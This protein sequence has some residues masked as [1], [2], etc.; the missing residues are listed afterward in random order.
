M[1]QTRNFTPEARF[2]Q[3]EG[4]LQDGNSR[5]NPT[6]LRPGERKL[7]RHFRQRYDERR[8]AFWRSRL[9]F[10]TA[11]SLVGE[12]FFMPACR[13]MGLF[14]SAAI[15]LLTAR[16]AA[17]EEPGAAM[18][19]LLDAGW[20]I[21]PQAR[22]AAD[23]QFPLL[24]ESADMN[25]DASEAIW[26]VL[27]QQRRFGEAQRRLD[28]HLRRW[29]NDLLAL[30]AKAWILI[31][32][33]SYS[34][35]FP[36]AERV[37]TA[38]IASA[39]KTEADRTEQEES[40]AF[41]GR[42]AGFFGGP[43]ADSV[44]QEERK[45][46]EKK[47]LARLDEPQRE[48]FEAARNGVLMRFIE[49]TDESAEAHA[50]ATAAAKAEKERTLADLHAERENLAVR[51]SEL[52]ERRKKLNDELKSEL[53]DI[54]K[55]DQPLVQQQ[56]RL[57]SQ[58]ANL[59]NDLLN[60]QSQLAV[61]QQLINQE[62]SS[63]LRQ[64]YLTQASTLALTIGRLQADLLASNTLV[65]NVRSQRAA[66]AG[67]R[68]AA[69]ANTAAQVGRLNDELA[70]IGKRER[71]SDGLEK[72]AARPVSASTSKVRSLT[73]QATALS[74]YDPFPLEAAKA[75]LLEAVR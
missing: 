28:E 50:R 26:L 22:A 63:S 62:R 29:P 72:R 21:T 40:I 13:G 16:L 51:Q 59:S 4:S 32:L 71:R 34:A 53:D 25:A 31:V 23:A 14:A 39:P 75:R 56:A 55:R 43:V 11:R 45:A 69:Q 7:A 61:L 41:L 49:V 10:T 68:T 2:R 6:L 64:Q 58:A 73:A 30:R 52:E 12:A 47:W 57:S 18:V 17:V 74:T 66:L 37:S 20:G 36:A 24:A 54:A 15:L 48:I 27:M 5:G 19:Q 44:S 3:R 33:K 46:L 35:A 9:S 70:E 42:L 38:L 8:Q 60:Y 1:K 67:Q 65:Q